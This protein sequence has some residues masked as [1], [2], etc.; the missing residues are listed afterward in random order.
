MSYIMVDVESDGPIPGDYSMISFG[1]VVVDDTL[2]KT[3][4]GRLQPISDKFIPEALAVS[5]YTREQ[6]MAFDE[7]ALVMQQFAAW[8]K[9]LSKD[10]HIF[11]S[12]NNGFGIPT[13]P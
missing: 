12:D 13:T 11:I 1:A 2:D 3:F 8:L 10:R 9:E 6:T 7:P 4:Y 5:G